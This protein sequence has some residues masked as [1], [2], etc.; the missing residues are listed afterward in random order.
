MF[1]GPRPALMLSSETV[2][3]VADIAREHDMLELSSRIVA[4]YVSNN[5]VPIPE[6]AILIR[7]VHTVLN[8][9]SEQSVEAPA[10]KPMVSIRR[11][12]TNDYLICLEDGKKFKML[13][14]YLRTKYHLSPEQYRAKWGL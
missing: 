7:N 3:R 14:R 9:L 10:V 1:C 2:I 13:K 6:L 5:S 8:A 12:V 11:S 4:A